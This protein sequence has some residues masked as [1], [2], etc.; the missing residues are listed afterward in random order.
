MPG[1]GGFFGWNEP[2]PAAI[3]T[4]LQRK[5]T[6]PSVFS[7]KSPSSCFAQFGDHLV[8]M[9][10]RIERLDLLQQALGQLLRR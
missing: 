8:E 10:L 9:E 3:T 2:P 4:T 1:I 6:P 5:T 7:S